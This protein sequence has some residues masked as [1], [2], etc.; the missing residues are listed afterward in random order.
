MTLLEATKTILDAVK[1]WCPQE[2]HDRRRPGFFDFNDPNLRK[3]VIRMEK[4]LEVLQFRAAK[5]LQRRR[6]KG[7]ADLQLLSPVC[8]HCGCTFVFGE[9][10]KRAELNWRGDIIRFDCPECEDCVVFLMIDGKC[11]TYMVVKPGEKR[12][13]DSGCKPTFT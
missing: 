6:H 10:A 1:T 7:W 5:S 4:R 12:L 2:R 11:Q 9:F 3:A 8:P 13:S